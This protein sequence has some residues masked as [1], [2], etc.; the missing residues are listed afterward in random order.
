MKNSIKCF[1]IVF[2]FFSSPHLLFAQNIKLTWKDLDHM[3]EYQLTTGNEG[4]FLHNTEVFS[5]DDEWI[6]YD[7][8][9]IDSQI[10]R[11]CCI[12]MVNVKSREIRL[13]YKTKHQTKYGPGV[14]AATF[15]PVKNE[16]L[17]I[18]GL[19]NCDSANPYSET[20]RTG[21]AVQIDHPE[22]PI[23]MDARNVYPPFTPGALR[24]GTHAHTWS[25]DGK[26]ISFTYNDAI[27]AQLAKNDKNKKDMRM[28]G[29]MAPYGPVKVKEFPSG[30]NNN[31]IMFTTIV[32]QVTGNPKPGSDE[33]EKAHGDGWVGKEG[34]V[35]K[36]GKRQ[37]RAIAFLGDT[38]DSAD[39]LLTE[40]Y[41]VNVPENIT[42]ALPGES[43]AGTKY[44]RPMP[45]KGT[46]Q[47]R[48]TYTADR[49]FPGIQGPRF[50]MRSTPDGS[51]LFFLMKD[52]HGVVQFY[53][54]SPNG[55]V[56]N[57]ITHNSFSVSTTFNVSPDGKF[58]A[59]GSGNNIYVTEITT[60]ITKEIT[61]DA[62]D[63]YSRVSNVNW[64][65]NGTMIAF[66]RKVPSG[67]NAYYQIFL[68][69]LKP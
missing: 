54:I 1:V 24:G 68:L 3:K 5:P 2:Y 59:Y 65:N 18:H 45:P 39:N 34:Y 58:L 52:D 67:N 26:W 30:E 33:I 4:H 47:K 31:G 23:F 41:I 64:S 17:F 36:D 62:P 9:N 42:S 38:R 29:V 7:T 50:W 53:A 66:N 32:T 63:K 20:R 16:V 10:A 27:M 56:I 21:V 49:K 43:L 6:V 44:S 35:R 28:V 15:D 25:G 69:Q 22:V 46:K 55:G 57:Q 61:N 19:S 40:V 37:K 60:G 51:R 11:N 48:L 8:R 13:L 12:K 14:A